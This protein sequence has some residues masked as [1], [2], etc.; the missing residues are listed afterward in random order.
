LTADAPFLAPTPIIA[1][2]IVCVVLTGMPKWVAPNNVNAPAV[3]AQNPSK[4][5]TLVIYCPM[6]LT[7]LQPPKR[8]PSAI[9]DWHDRIIHSAIGSF[10]VVNPETIKASQIIPIDFCA[11]FPPCPRL[12]VEEEIICSFLN[13]LL[14]VEGDALLNR[15]TTNVEIA[16]DITIPSIGA[17]KMNAIILINPGKIIVLIPECVTAAPTNPPTRVWEE[18]DGSPIHHVIRFQVI[19]ATRA[20]AITV[21]LSTS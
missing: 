5:F 6:V 4:G 20:E 14:M 1:P 10:L 2:V 21:I 13:I 18:L 8:V 15:K 12:N 11:S 19:A 16:N 17:I 7:I 3:S 9:A